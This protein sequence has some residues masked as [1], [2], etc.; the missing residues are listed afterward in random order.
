MK[1]SVIQLGRTPQRAFEAGV[2]K[3]LYL[4]G[5]ASPSGIAAKESFKLI[6][7]LPSRHLDYLDAYLLRA[8]AW[9]GST[10]ANKGRYPRGIPVSVAPLFVKAVEMYLDPQGAVVC[11]QI[12]GSR[13]KE[14]KEV[15][16]R[17]HTWDK[18]FW[19]G[20]TLA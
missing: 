16:G 11:F 6:G 8:E 14:I 4:F 2:A 12:T 13:A 7:E 9:F 10:H 20:G 3:S 15:E 19:F 5:H 18:V 1:F 17:K